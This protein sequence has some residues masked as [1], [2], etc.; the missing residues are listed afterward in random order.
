MAALKH[1]TRSMVIP[2]CATR[3]RTRATRNRKRRIIN[4]D[5]PNLL[6]GTAAWFELRFPGLDAAPITRSSHATGSRAGEGSSGAG[7]THR[8]VYQSHR[9]S[10]AGHHWFARRYKR[11]AVEEGL[12]TLG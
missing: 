6:A 3:R 9:T 1:S 5:H 2:S 4:H 8:R 12:G 11:K 7:Q 10:F